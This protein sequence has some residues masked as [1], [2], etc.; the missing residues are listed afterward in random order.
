[1]KK[2][3]R[4]IILK[5]ICILLGCGV[6]GF[7]SA[8]LMNH[9]VGR[10]MLDFG[11]LGELLAPVVPV[12]FVGG[13]VVLCAVAVGLY[14][15]AKKAA[16]GWDGEDEEVIERAEKKLS[17]PLILA[18]VMMVLNF[19]FFSA[20][21]QVFEFTAFGERWGTLLFPVAMATFLLGY[22]W[23]I[24]VTN[25]VVNLEKRL[26]P[27]K[28]GNIFDTKFQKVWMESCDELEKQKIYECG[29][30]GYSAG[31][32][33]CM[34]CWVVSMFGQLWAETGLLPVIM[35]CIIWMSMLMSYQISCIRLE[36]RK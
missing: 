25:K 16:A 36:K 2:T 14:L 35:V 30:R 22:V 3:N 32:I 12:L 20:S 7:L 18:N 4:K 15:R 5:F 19:F 1:M 21:I 26:N 23:I 17:I 28:Q 33:A 6:L 31:S 34:V 11:A 9:L 24:L 29:Y 10:D 13:N 27:E 8:M